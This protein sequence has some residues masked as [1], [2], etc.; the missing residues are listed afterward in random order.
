MKLKQWEISK[1]K[2]DILLYQ[3]IV[4]DTYIALIKENLKLVKILLNKKVVSYNQGQKQKFYQSR[5]YHLQ[6][7]NLIGSTA[8]HLVK[9]ILLKRNF[10]INK[11]DRCVGLDRKNGVFT[12]LNKMLSNKFS[13]KYTMKLDKLNK[14][15]QLTQSKLNKIYYDAKKDISSNFSSETF[16]FHECIKLFHASNK[17]LKEGYLSFIQKYKIDKT[18]ALVGTKGKR[19]LKKYSYINKHNCLDIIR[20]SRNAYIHLANAKS[21]NNG[22]KWYMVNY[23]ITLT[24]EE[25]PQHFNNVK[26]VGSKDIRELFKK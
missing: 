25:Y 14:I 19:Y 9:L 3:P 15:S 11:T 18:P 10:I 20:E 12:G 17:S 1:D 7:M 21:E 2:F 24:R 22:L 5:A 23:L 16:K 8:E 4:V 26:L 13:Q 6:K